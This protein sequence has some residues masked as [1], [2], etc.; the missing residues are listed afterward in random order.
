MIRACPTPLGRK[1]KNIYPKNPTP[2]DRVEKIINDM[3]EYGVSL[4]YLFEPDDLLDSKDIPK[5][6][7]AY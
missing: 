1:L 7:I 3:F 2:Y 6:S 5:V 4:E